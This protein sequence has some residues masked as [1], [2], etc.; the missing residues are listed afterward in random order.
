MIHDD[1]PVKSFKTA[2]AFEQWLNKNHKKA[3]GL[4][5][6]IA[7]AKTGIQSIAFPDALDI[8]LCYGWIDGMRRSLDEDYYMQKFTPRRHNSVWSVINRNKVAE[9]IKQGRMKEAGHAAIEEAKKNG[10]WDNAYHS[11]ANAEVPEDLQ[12]ALNKNKKAK[13]F[14]AKLSSQNRFAIIYRLHQVKREETKKK[15]IEE[16]IRMLEDGKTIYPQK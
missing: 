2:I 15:K 8:A 11:P 7:K 6:K 1:Y 9:L 4:W 12:K 16:Y 14:F 5:L 10:R 3:D 13:A